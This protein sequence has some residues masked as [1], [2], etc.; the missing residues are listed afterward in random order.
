MLT[1]LRPRTPLMRYLLL[2]E[3][4]DTGAGGNGGGGNGA[5]TPTPVVFTPEQTAAIN[6]Q[7]T[8]ATQAAATKAAADKQAEIE[9]YLAEQKR[10]A[11][12]ADADAL[13]QA[14]ARAEAAEQRA[15]TTEA[16]AK[17]ATASATA[18]LVLLAAGMPAAVKVGDKD[19]P[20]AAIDD[21]VK[22]LEVTGDDNTTTLTAKT[23]ALKSRL[24][25]LFA[26]PEIKQAPPWQPAGVTPPAPPAGGAAA[27]AG[28]TLAEYGAELR[29]ANRLPVASS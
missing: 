15:A 29:K 23:E 17:I 9:T 27:L 14:T 5:G 18:R 28:K 13:T 20:N 26:A 24:P 22:L 3:G 12:L 16:A 19:Q 11:D 7:V 8:A 25:T 2:N 1:D 6:A 4:A 21:A 10:A